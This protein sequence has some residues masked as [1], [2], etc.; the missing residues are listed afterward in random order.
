M[1]ERGGD[2]GIGVALFSPGVGVGEVV[3]RGRA[4][5][6]T[7]VGGIGKGDEAGGTGPAVGQLGQVGRSGL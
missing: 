1:G 2:R 6:P 3:G 7:R 4:P 5:V